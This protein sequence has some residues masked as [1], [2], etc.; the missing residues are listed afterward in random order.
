MFRWIV[1]CVLLLWVSGQPA[2]AGAEVEVKLLKPGGQVA[3][4]RVVGEGKLLISVTGADQRPL[5]GLGLADLT[6]SRAGRIAKVTAL[7]PIAE[8]LEVPRHIVLVLDNSDSMRQ[9]NAVE[10][11]LAGV[12]E[13]LKIVRPID[14]VQVVVFDSR[15][16]VTMG[17]RDLHVRTFASSNPGELKDF[18]ASTYRD[19]MTASTV[20]YEAMVAGLEIVRTLPADAPKFM[21]VFSDGEDLNSAFKSDVVSRAAQGLARFDAYAIDY[22][23]GPATDKFLNQFT[24]GSHGQVWKATTE[25]ALVPI[26]QS[27]ASTMQYYYVLSYLFPPTGKLTVTP[28]ALTVDEIRTPGTTSEQRDAAP[29][30]TATIDAATLTLHPTVESSYGFTRWKVSVANAAGSVAMLAG[31]GTPPAQLDV[32]LPTGNLPALAADG[33]LAVTM[34]LLDRKGQALVLTAPPV[35]VKLLQTNVGL[36]VVPP[37][38]NIEEVRTIDASPMLGHL[39]F[40]KGS[41]AIPAQYAR[42]AGP[43]ETAG[44]NEQHYHDTL[45]KYYQVL[46]IIGKRLAEHGSAT[47]TLVGCNA[48]TGPEKGSRKLSLQR[49]EAVRDY[50]QGVWRIAPERIRIETRN[51]PEMPS[52]SRNEEGQAENRRVEIRSDDPA[53]LDL[54]RSTYLTSRIDVPALT[55]NPEVVS[56]HG[57]AGW[58][59]RVANAAG[60]V[61]EVSGAGE[62]ARQVT[63]P[64]PTGNLTALAAAGDLTVNL[65]LQDRKGENVVLAPVP[66]KVNFIQTSQRLAERQ[67]LRVQEK[68]ALILF[69]FDKDAIDARN[70]AIVDTIVARLKELPQATA[71]I[72]GH[73]DNIGK[74]TYNVKLSERRALAVHKLLA[75]AYGDNAGERLRYSGVGP[76]S[77]LYDNLTPEA[78]SFNRTVTITLDYLSAGE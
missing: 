59:V 27:V 48:D 57:I 30:V 65:A 77:P 11:L 16:T 60:S 37:V 43:E 2:T 73:T 26:F 8:S 45:E 50:L 10:P 64:L 33:A 49:A 61:S 70:Q 35:M 47:I 76:A 68:Y 74:E 28:V 67:D 55:L 44:F 52:T 62:P 6:V 34:E 42:F 56:P 31:E 29:V 46:N 58:K 21:V 40:P 39:Y 38:L 12:D 24:S 36:A 5:L 17:G 53:I 1:L 69:D 19:S 23:P 13:L 66:V 54:I 4:D 75:A 71:E 25:T 18:V 78:R 63:V 32:P 15:Q 20:L 7:Q 14:Q 72:V 51:L 3:V 41:S 9:R 22:M